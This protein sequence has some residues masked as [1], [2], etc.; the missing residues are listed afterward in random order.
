MKMFESLFQMYLNEFQQKGEPVLKAICNCAVP[1][2][3]ILE[4]YK[5][6][7]PIEMMNDKEKSEMKKYVNGLFPGATP[8]FRLDA[9]K[10][11]Y[12]IG[13]LL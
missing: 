5:T 1:S 13:T 12:T 9:C 11:I 6:I 8:Q 3:V 7:A 4:K 10:I 2:K